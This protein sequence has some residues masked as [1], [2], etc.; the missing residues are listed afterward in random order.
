MKGNTDS[1]VI[2][3]SVSGMDCANCAKTIERG[4]GK[5]PGVDAVHV[6]FPTERLE[7]HG[8]ASVDEIVDK[9]RQLGFGIDQTD[10]QT[11]AHSAVT[12]TDSF[13][14]FLWSER[15]TRAA[16]IAAIVIFALALGNL[17]M[18]SGAADL[19]Q[20]ALV[21][22]VLVVGVPI[23]IKGVRALLYARQITI[24]LLM[25]LAATGAL[26]IGAYGEAAAVMLLFALGEAL[27]GYSAARSRDAI[28]SLVGLQPDSA[29]VINQHDGH[30]HYRE[31][32]VNN[33][34]RGQQVIV[35]A[36]ERIPADGRVVEG[37]S[38]VDESAITG[39]ATPVT[40]GV[41]SEVFAGTING[42]GTLIIEVT[43]K[44]EDFA[45]ARI[46]RL[47]EQ[48]QASRSPAERY[49]D[50][51]AHWYTPAVVALAVLVAVMPPLVA[52]QPFLNPANGETGWLYRG[53]ALLIIACP[54][55][56]VLSIPVTVVSALARL[57]RDGVLAKGGAQLSELAR[58][59]VFAFDKTG[60]LTHGRPVVSG[61]RG[62]ECAHDL[63]SHE[64]CAPCDE[65]VAVAAAV[66][67]G[68]SHPLAN[69]VMHEASQ[70][71]VESRYDRATEVQSHAGRGVSGYIK[72]AHISVGNAALAAQ[73][74]GVEV[75]LADAQ[76]EDASHVVVTRDDKALGLIEV[77]DTIRGEVSESI[78]ALKALDAEYRFV[79]LT[80]DR[81]EV[82]EALAQSIGGIDEVRSELLPDQKLAAVRELEGTHGKVAMVGDGINDTPALAGAQLG[83][84]MGARG[85]AQAMEAADIVLMQD[86]I[87]MLTH[88]I[89]IARKTRT[90]IIENVALSLI[91][92]LI[93]LGLAIPGL[94]TLWMA[95]LADVGTTLIVTLNGMRILRERAAPLT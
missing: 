17:A 15:Q 65:V 81:R 69:A 24:D 29:T 87:G 4:V 1:E 7:A 52:G 90:R 57:A 82:A 94:A 60:T 6:S 55:A 72:G 63:D 34:Q 25:A 42:E 79:M 70:R 32:N 40:R 21:T 77:S 26:F 30:T 49:V 9:V 58:V 8:S 11:R 28:G 56:L 91:L 66:E 27:E 62:I 89:H 23:S 80:G 35:R 10:E 78:H 50:R 53:L 92:K 3:L 41:E 12:G 76:R 95:V 5:L 61:M 2:Q 67:S 13:L 85:S 75:L 44:P 18:L 88:A 19:L 64:G 20:L 71:L 48:A 47:V 14:Q 73:S 68:S 45:I 84:A 33:L 39:E 16:L 51:F 43:S 93:F 54:C 74:D 86:R 38:A 22:A 46:A 31:L 36:G 59:K 37:A 83:I